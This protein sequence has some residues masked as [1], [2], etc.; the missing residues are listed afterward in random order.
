MEV[1]RS[2][3][4]YKPLGESAKNLSIMR[5]MDKHCLGNPTEGVL[6]KNQGL[7][8]WIRVNIFNNKFVS[9]NMLT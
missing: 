1:N 7:I 6:H 9:L 8:Y 4:Y 5:L 3:I 2:N